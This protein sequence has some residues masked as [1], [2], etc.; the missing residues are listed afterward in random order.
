MILAKILWA[1]F[2]IGTLGYGA[3][4]VLSNA[5]AGYARSDEITVGCIL[6]AIGAVMISY[7]KEIFSKG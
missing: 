5:F 3:G 4:L 7:R 6:M 1:L 2:E